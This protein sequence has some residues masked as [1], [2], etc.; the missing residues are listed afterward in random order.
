MAKSPRERFH[1]AIGYVS[2]RRRGLGAIL[3]V[4]SGLYAYWWYNAAYGV[5][6]INEF[7]WLGRITFPSGPIAGNL[8][9]LFGL[10]SLFAFHVR[11]FCLYVVG[12]LQWS[13]LFLVYLY[14]RGLKSRSG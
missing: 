8:I 7:I 3:F 1:A 13:S 6:P 4:Y 10:S 9:N 11:I 5:S 12:L 2:F 14:W